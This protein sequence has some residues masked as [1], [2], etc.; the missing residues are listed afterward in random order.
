MRNFYL[1]FLTLAFSSF[2]VKILAQVSEKTHETQTANR[3]LAQQFLQSSQE[4]VEKDGLF[5]QTVVSQPNFL[6]PRRNRNSD[7]ADSSIPIKI[8]VRIRN[9]SRK[10]IRLSAPTFTMPILVGGNDQK[11]PLGE[12]CRLIIL[13]AESDYPWVMPSQS[14]TFFLEGKIYRRKNRL[15]M[16]GPD[17]LGCFWGSTDLKPGK[18]KVQFQYHL[19]DDG[20]VEVYRPER[21][22][23]SG[24][25]TGKVLTPA[26][27][28]TLT[29]D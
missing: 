13:P 25:W 26:V 20:E 28:F 10:T 1:V 18:Y 21:K 7:Q 9:N 4:V 17:R 2:G 27:E 14:V 12:G 8:G 3:Q 15:R 6:I 29:I 19:S 5:F 24:V 23:L 22:I 16:G 11:I